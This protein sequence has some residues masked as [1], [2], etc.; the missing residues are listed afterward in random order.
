MGPKEKQRAPSIPTRKQPA[1]AA[2]R[3]THAERL[4]E[5][6]RGTGYDN[7]SGQASGTTQTQRVSTRLSRASLA[8][9][10]DGFTLRP[11]ARLEFTDLGA[12][13]WHSPPPIPEEEREADVATDVDNGE[14]DWLFDPDLDPDGDSD[15][16]EYLKKKMEGPNWESG[17]HMQNAG[18][19]GQIQLAPN[20]PVRFYDF[21]N[22]ASNRLMF[23]MALPQMFVPPTRGPA[24][25]R[26]SM[27]RFRIANPEFFSININPDAGDGE[28]GQSEQRSRRLAAMI[29]YFAGILNIDPPSAG[30]V[31]TR[32]G[33][34]NNI[35][36]N[37]NKHTIAHML[38]PD[39]PHLRIG[40]TGVMPHW[41]YDTLRQNT[42]TIAI[43]GQGGDGVWSS[44]F[45]NAMDLNYTSGGQLV[46]PTLIIF[47]AI[48]LALLAKAQKASAGPQIWTPMAFDIGLFKT[49]RAGCNGGKKT[50]TKASFRGEWLNVPCPLNECLLASL[51]FDVSADRSTVGR[52]IKFA[53]GEHDLGLSSL[54]SRFQI[55]RGL[56][57]LPVS[58]LIPLSSENLI[59]IAT[60][61]GVEIHLYISRDGMICGDPIRVTCIGAS[62]LVRLL[63]DR[64]HIYVS[65]HTSKMVRNFCGHCASSYSGHY[66]TCPVKCKDGLRERL[67]G[68]CFRSHPGSPCSHNTVLYIEHC[69][70]YW[71]SA[72]DPSVRAHQLKICQQK[73]MMEND[74][75]GM[76]TNPY[77]SYKPGDWYERHGITA[78]EDD[79]IHYDIETTSPGEGK[80][81]I[82]THIAVIAK[83]ETRLFEWAISTDPWKDYLEYLR[84]MFSRAFLM[85]KVHGQSYRSLPISFYED[86]TT[87]DG[88]TYD[89]AAWAIFSK[90]KFIIV[91]PL[92]L[93]AYN[94]A[95][96]DHYPLL[97][98]LCR[99]EKEM[100]IKLSTNMEPVNG[101][102]LNFSFK[103]HRFCSFVTSD[104]MQ[105][106]GGKSLRHLAM[107]VAAAMIA[108]GVNNVEPV[109]KDYFPYD[110][111]DSCDRLLPASQWIEWSTF[112]SPIFYGGTS[113]P[114][115]FAD[116]LDQGVNGSQ[117]RAIVK[118][119][120]GV[121][122]VN[123][124]N[125][126]AYYCL[127]DVQVL[128][129]CDQYFC[130]LVQ[131]QFL[132]EIY[133]FATARQYAAAAAYELCSEE[134]K[135]V[136]FC[137][138][139]RDQDLRLRATAHAGR[140][141]PL[142]QET[143]ISAI[144]SSAKLHQ[145][146]KANDIDAISI[147]HS[148]DASHDHPSGPSNV[149]QMVIPNTT[150]ESL[151][152]E[153]QAE[154]D[155]SG[156]YSAIQG[157]GL[158]GILS[159]HPLPK[160][161]L[162]RFQD[163]CDIQSSLAHGDQNHDWIMNYPKIFR[164][165][166]YPNT[167]TLDPPIRRRS[168]HGRILTDLLPFETTINHLQ[169]KLALQ[170]HYKIVLLEGWL[171]QGEPRNFYGPFIKKCEAIK[172]R[173]KTQVP[174]NDMLTFVGK[175]MPNALFGDSLMKIYES[176]TE[177]VDESDTIKHTKFMMKH[178]DWTACATLENKIRFK[179]L[180]KNYRANKMIFTGS[181]ILGHAQL[182]LFN[183]L[184]L[185]WPDIYEL[186]TN[187]ENDV[188]RM[189]RL[190]ANY[191][192]YG[193]TD[194]IV[195]PYREMRKLHDMP[196]SM[197]YMWSEMKDYFLDTLGPNLGEPY[198]ASLNP[199][200]MRMD[201]GQIGFMKRE[202][203]RIWQH[204]SGP[205][206]IDFLEVIPGANVDLTT[207][208]SWY[209]AGRDLIVLC[210]YH[211]TTK[212]A[213]KRDLNLHSAIRKASHHYMYIQP[214][215]GV[216]PTF[217][218]SFTIFKRTGLGIA[219]DASLS[220]TIRDLKCVRQMK[221]WW[222]GR[223]FG[224]IVDGIFEAGKGDGLHP[225]DAQEIV[226][227]PHGHFLDPVIHIDTVEEDASLVELQVQTAMRS[228]IDEFEFLD[229]L[230]P[231]CCGSECELSMR[232]NQMHFTCLRCSS[233]TTLES[234]NAAIFDQLAT[235]YST[236]NSAAEMDVLS[237][238]PPRK[239]RKKK[240]S[241]FRS[242]IDDAASCSDEEDDDSD[243]SY[244]E[245][246]D[247]IDDS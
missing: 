147:M 114:I 225:R 63:Y 194:C 16:E 54:R 223:V 240:N 152:A 166:V 168:D 126:M 37:K 21:S 184:G 121:E 217:E 24:N 178:T 150:W 204:A 115:R 42:A 67:C 29:T 228:T 133:P 167:S 78:S 95:K 35:L 55:I 44:V 66:H 50:T 99:Y 94:G 129:R 148:S 69:S 230:R 161:E 17:I 151:E 81:K 22:P 190:I 9:S 208:P 140:V 103:F 143:G 12:D 40:R 135:S 239:L 170:L 13:Q 25:A 146:L 235:D 164:V 144:S 142:T 122:M 41:N 19:A 160:S 30:L 76:Y 120:A 88:V 183:V 111:I 198:H 229:A 61:L 214:V 113:P 163:I 28:G 80:E 227:V 128:K 232:K 175:T 138:S 247:F 20:G 131:D 221:S 243:S 32:A 219:E 213:V 102:V 155:I 226:S 216:E 159:E 154:Y 8:S 98:A 145:V 224:R 47:R 79:R 187:M 64:E 89:A 127:K 139:S 180:K 58:G 176:E 157:F 189:L 125:F 109:L 5:T 181:Q 1:R 72:S 31:E 106:A 2:A 210:R 238:T 197:H 186:P 141:Y 172:R 65:K 83:N 188:P 90:K 18:F 68:K 104:T 241:L 177:V 162:D 56:L 71:S 174:K 23:Q 75:S 199:G 33:P 38:N 112:T 118:V 169:L 237:Q 246:G 211:G 193:D 62:R 27:F 46:L 73:A 45:V 156:M 218:S 153:C 14:F 158:F 15:D 116:F 200:G 53:S 11:R 84:T 242:F 202:N 134:S 185:I 87:V 60:G 195:G 86:T 196:A 108:D 149:F 124:N 101:R 137:P 236:Q 173:G 206:D 70:R 105:L 234:M 96:F 39:L 203:L 59:S 91:L 57:K 77:A 26:R 51:L 117:E 93:N 192:T 97:R 36:F 165:S 209:T 48:Y 201:C 244:S 191:R 212:G 179:G 222:S 34:R 245:M 49:I 205:K 82:T 100:G 136:M 74:F 6:D 130:N 7:R 182:M 220:F 92:Y 52:M 233:D 119:Q 85:V 10:A 123:V 3:P 207:V 43:H 171:Y 132:L 110:L 215:R 4:R 107:D 231:T